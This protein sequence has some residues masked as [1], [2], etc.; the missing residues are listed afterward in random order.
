MI[1]TNAKGA[2]VASTN[3][4]YNYIQFFDEWWIKASENKVL[5]R[6]CGYDRSI[7]MNS[8]DIIIKIFDEKGEFIGILNSATPCNVIL[9]KP[10]AFYGDSN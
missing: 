8:E 3:G 9:D 7:Q 4:T 1:L 10:L 6:E 2:N 5:V